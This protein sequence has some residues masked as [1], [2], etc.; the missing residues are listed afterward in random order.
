MLK[1]KLAFE[2]R[3]LPNMKAYNGS[4]PTRGSFHYEEEK[5]NTMHAK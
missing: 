3:N 4:S 1:I 5:M 2:Q